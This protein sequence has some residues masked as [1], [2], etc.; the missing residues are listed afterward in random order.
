MVAYIF[1]HW[2]IFAE[3]KLIAVMFPIHYVSL[4]GHEE[5]KF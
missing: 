5:L 3:N 2:H 1:V 4:T